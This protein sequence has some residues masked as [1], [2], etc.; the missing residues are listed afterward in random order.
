MFCYKVVY[1]VFP[2]SYQELFEAHE[3][4][5]STLPEADKEFNAIM[6]LAQEVQRLSSS[7]GINNPENPYTTVSPQVSSSLHDPHTQY[8]DTQSHLL[9]FVTLIIYVV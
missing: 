2:F 8:L 6:R 1:N 5:K 9:A 7:I 3:Q 4:F